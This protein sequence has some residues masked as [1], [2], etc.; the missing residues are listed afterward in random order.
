LRYTHS[1]VVGELGPQIRT[2]INIREA[3]TEDALEVGNLKEVLCGW[4]LEHLFDLDLSI[5][6]H[7]KPLFRF[8]TAGVGHVDRGSEKCDQ[9]SYQHYLIHFYRGDRIFCMTGDEDTSIQDPLENEFSDTTTYT[10]QT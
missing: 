2:I 1:I 5:G 7:P 4:I 3:G 10:K 8:I 9:Y 6:D